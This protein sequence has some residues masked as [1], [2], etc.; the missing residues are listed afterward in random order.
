MHL[1]STFC[2]K[3]AYAILLASAITIA[4][5]QWRSFSLWLSM[6]NPQGNMPVIDENF[7]SVR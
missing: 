5:S 3:E 4:S 7:L 2:R 1:L 6:S